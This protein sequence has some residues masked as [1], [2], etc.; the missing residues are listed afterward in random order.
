MNVLCVN[1]DSHI[2]IIQKKVKCN[3]NACYQMN[4]TYGEITA[5]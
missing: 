5:Q 4:D 3:L 2:K 1:Q